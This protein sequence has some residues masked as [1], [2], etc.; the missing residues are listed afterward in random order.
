M[1]HK[2]LVMS[3]ILYALPL[4]KIAR[5]QGESLERLQKVDLRFCF[6]VPSIPNYTATLTEAHGTTIQHQAEVCA[7]C[8]LERMNRKASTTG[9]FQYLLIR[10][11][12]HLSQLAVRFRDHIRGPISIPDPVSHANKSCH[13]IQDSIPGLGGK[14]IVPSVLCRSYTADLL[15]DSFPDFVEVYIN[16]SINK[17]TVPS[18]VLEMTQNTC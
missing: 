12:S 10:K 8:H 14:S 17:Q 11:P 4:V 3:R 2:G 1:A 5:S 7:F 16:G 18:V 15:D 13:C 6:G 9:M